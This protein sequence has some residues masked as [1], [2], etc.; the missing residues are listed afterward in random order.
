MGI[1]GTERFMQQKA[2]ENLAADVKSGWHLDGARRLKLFPTQGD[3][4][5]FFAAIENY[6]AIFDSLNRDLVDLG[7]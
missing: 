5:L 6:L 2:G 7:A 1:A 4:D 3:Y